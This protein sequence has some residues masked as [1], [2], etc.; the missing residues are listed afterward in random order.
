MKKDKNSR[1]YII[2]INNISYAIIFFLL[3]LSIVYFISRGMGDSSVVINSTGIYQQDQIQAIEGVANNVVGRINNIIAISAIFFAVVVSSVSVFQFIKIKDLDKINENIILKSK[4]FEIDLIN[5]KKENNLLKDRY[6]ELKAL[7]KQLEDGLITSRVEFNI[8]KIQYEI[9]KLYISKQPLYINGLERLIVD[10]LNL[11]N[12]HGLEIN[13]FDKAKL[14][15][16]LVHEVYIPKGLYEESSKLLRSCLNLLANEDCESFKL[17]IYKDL[18]CIAINK[19]DEEVKED[20]LREIERDNNLVSYMNEEIFN[21]HYF[22]VEYIDE[23]FRELKEIE[24]YFS[25]LFFK[26]LKSNVD[27]GYFKNFLDEDEFRDYYEQ[28]VKKY[29]EL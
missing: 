28:L 17:L 24:F 2:N 5:S 22:G 20:L 14:Q 15:Y 26:L 13:V 10:T 29:I 23:V 21:L 7:Q 27:E 11:V 3:L 12:T 9:D 18:I 6:E 19:D 8:Q 16:E 1:V 25:R 4:E